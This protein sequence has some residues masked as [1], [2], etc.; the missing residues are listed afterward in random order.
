MACQDLIGYW[1]D[2]PATELWCITYME[3]SFSGFFCFP[4]LLIY[5]RGFHLQLPNLSVFIDRYNLLIQAV[6]AESVW[7]FWSVLWDL[8]TMIAFFP[9]ES[10]TFVK[11]DRSKGHKREPNVLIWKS[12]GKTL[13][14]TVSSLFQ[15][16]GEFKKNKH[17][18][19][20]LSFS[21]RDGLWIQKQN[22]MPHAEVS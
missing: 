22:R 2:E 4:K 17:L 9:H 10:M 14:I 1:S 11:I 8:Y 21:E 3:F 7:M 20:A 18:K 5:L 15:A 19:G 16:V 6:E 13:N 12:A